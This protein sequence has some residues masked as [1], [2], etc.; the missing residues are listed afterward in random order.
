MLFYLTCCS[1]LIFPWREE[2]VSHYVAYSEASV[3]NTEGYIGWRSPTGVVNST[4]TGSALVVG[5]Q[6]CKV[7]MDLTEP[8]QTHR[9]PKFKDSFFIK[10]SPQGASKPDKTFS[11]QSLKTS[12]L[13]LMCFPLFQFVSV[14]Y[15]QVNYYYS[16][17]CWRINSST[18]WTL[19][20]EQLKFCTAYDKPE[21]P[22]SVRSGRF[23]RSKHSCLRTPWELCAIITPP[24][25]C[26]SSL[27][28]KGPSS[29]HRSTYL[30]FR[31]QQLKG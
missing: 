12:Q 13:I 24:S 31:M 7:Q 29:L 8:I 30:L 6:G 15:F 3:L 25:H 2:N 14:L 19:A 26:C 5:Q 17:S 11:P 16:F 28:I 22:V 23:R 27:Y 4:H 1:W 21:I 9:R 20:D 18:F 10:V